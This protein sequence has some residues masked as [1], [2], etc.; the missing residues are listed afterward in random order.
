MTIETLRDF[1]NWCV[2]INVVI[3]A[4]STVSMFL[5][6]G[7]GSKIHAKMF[8]IDATWVRQA[9]FSFLVNYKIAL[10]VFVVVPWIA[11]HLMGS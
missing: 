8:D 11:V 9:Y 7:W 4:I 10:L 2:G 3:F 6:G 5:L 1:L